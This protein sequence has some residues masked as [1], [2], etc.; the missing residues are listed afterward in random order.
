MLAT[1][2]LVLIAAMLLQLGV[3]RQREYLADATGAQSP[4]CCRWLT[5]WR[6]WRLPQGQP[7]ERESRDGVAVCGQ[8][9]AAEGLA[10]LFM[11]HLPLEERILVVLR[12]LDGY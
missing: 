2:I 9:A 12:A 6:H 3:S 11:T 7:D 5:R 4:A 1:I 10:T 8:P